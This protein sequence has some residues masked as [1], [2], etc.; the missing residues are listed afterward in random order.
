VN[1][2]AIASLPLGLALALGLLDPEAAALLAEPR[3]PPWTPSGFVLVPALDA[4][5]LYWSRVWPLDGGLI[6]PTMPP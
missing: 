5:D 4:A 6:T 1:R 3:V 2:K